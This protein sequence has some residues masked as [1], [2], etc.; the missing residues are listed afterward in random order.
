MTWVSPDRPTVYSWSNPDGGLWYG[1]TETPETFHVGGLPPGKVPQ[2]LVILLSEYRDVD[3]PVNGY[4]SIWGFSATWTWVGYTEGYYSG[5]RTA[6]NAVNLGGLVSEPAVRDA[7]WAATYMVLSCT[8]GTIIYDPLSLPPINGPY[9]GNVYPRPINPGTVGN[10]TTTT[11]TGT[12]F[13]TV[14]VL[15]PGSPGP[16]EPGGGPGT[17]GDPGT[18]SIRNI[19]TGVVTPIG[20]TTWTNG[21][22]TFDLPEGLPA[23]TYEVTVVNP[24]GQSITY[25]ITIGEGSLISFD[26]IAIKSIV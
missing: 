20:V 11:I 25:T 14:P 12:G 21:Q 3:G 19:D 2:S 26:I 9:I 23:G 22:I 10:P 6:P 18:V 7:N 16:G 8:D 4:H 5:T 1:L 17:V 15:V 24:W 13:G